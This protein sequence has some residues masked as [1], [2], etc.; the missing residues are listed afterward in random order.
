MHSMVISFFFLLDEPESSHNKSSLCLAI[1]W[2][3]L[4]SYFLELI[5]IMRIYKVHTFRGYS[6]A[7]D[8]VRAYTNPASKTTCQDIRASE[9][10]F[11]FSYMELGWH[12]FFTQGMICCVVLYICI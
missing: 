4:L 11:P 5:R 7:I 8:I 9:I 6:Q 2:V 3:D 1:H 10:F 12:R